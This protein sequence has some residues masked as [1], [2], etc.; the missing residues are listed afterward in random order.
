MTISTPPAINIVQ[1]ETANYFG[2]SKVALLS[3]SRK[4]AHALPRQIAMYVCRKQTIYSL[5]EIGLYFGPRDHTTVLHSIRKIT[6]LMREND[7]VLTAVLA[8]T[9]AVRTKQGIKRATEQHQ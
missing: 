1:T 9:D 5:P 4:P 2:M 3:D 8:I 7:A 6:K